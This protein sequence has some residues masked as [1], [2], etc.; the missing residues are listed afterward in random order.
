[1]PAGP[2]DPDEADD[3]LTKLR[4]DITG[5]RG[6]AVLLETTAAGHGEGRGAAPQK[7]CVAERLG[8]NPLPTLPELSRLTFSQMVAACG[9][10]VHMFADS[11]GQSQMQATRRWFMLGVRPYADL[12]QWELSEKFETDIKNHV[13]GAGVFPGCRWPE[14]GL[15]K[16]GR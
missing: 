7:D 12:L 6:K 4:S 2:D 1:M 16:H 11:D 3:P 8:P 10:P 9:A 14:P 5:A 15:P 13:P